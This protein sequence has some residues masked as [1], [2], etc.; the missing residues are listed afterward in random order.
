[1]KDYLVFKLG[2][3]GQCIFE[4]NSFYFTQIYDKPSQKFIKGIY[5]ITANGYIALL[6]FGFNEI[7]SG[8]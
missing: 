2:S 7:R 4:K 8:F 1:M 5:S 3:F 6:E